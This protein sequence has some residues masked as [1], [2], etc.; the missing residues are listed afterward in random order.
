[1]DCLHI[2]PSTRCWVKR[3]DTS[4]KI[5]SLIRGDRYIKNGRSSMMWGRIKSVPNWDTSTMHSNEQF[6]KEAIHSNRKR[7][8][9][10]QNFFQEGAFRQ[11]QKMRRINRWRGDKKA[12]Q[13]EEAARARWGYGWT[14][15]MSVAPVR[16]GP[17][18]RETWERC[19][20]AAR[21]RQGQ[22]RRLGV[23]VGLRFYSPVVGGTKVHECY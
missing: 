7:G 23:W 4:L 3:Q 18:E 10:N 22:R 8:R 11:F 2:Q 16:T 12:I 20:W 15:H 13:C 14:G 1:M 21:K 19:R 6:K 9:F 17:S 5:H